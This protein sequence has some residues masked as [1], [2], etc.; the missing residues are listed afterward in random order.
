MTKRFSHTTFDWQTLARPFSV[1][2]P[3]EDVTDTAFRRFIMTC[4]RPDVMFTEFVSA[5]GLCSAGIE[6]VRHR[7]A[8]QPEE[9]PLIAQ[10][11]GNVPEHYATTVKMLIELGFDGVDINMGCPVP[12]VV[13]KGY[14]S[15]LIENP[16]LAQ[17][18]ILATQEAA[19]QALPVSIKTRLGYS[20]LDTDRWAGFLLAFRPAALI[21]HG[22]VAQDMSKHPA[23]WDEI[24][25]VVALRNALSNE[26]T[27]VGNGDVH[28]F[29][30]IH[31]KHTRYGVDGAMVARGIFKNPFVFRPDGFSIESM[32]RTQRLNLLLQHA[33]LFTEA[34]GE[35]KRYAVLK[36]YF[37]IYAANFPGAAELREHLVETKSLAEAH[38]L[39]QPF[40][41]EDADGQEAPPTAQ[42]ES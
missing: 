21:M 36:K 16:L 17:E 5:D 6:K 32:S 28:S 12:K 10:I 39:L 41:N 15:R 34:W 42:A 19:G 35:N 25:K 40:L 1:L 27:I 13:K 31:E 37:K 7:L 26:T 18:L 24:A 8:Y 14:C 22:R 4:G 3:M 23:N 29:A 33:A 11:W 38:T 9:R 30:D 2:A 20:C